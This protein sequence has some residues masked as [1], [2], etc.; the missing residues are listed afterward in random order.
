MSTFL[1]LTNDA[2]LEAGVDL[3]EL[4]SVNFASANS[5]MYARFKRWVRRAYKDIQIMRND[6]QYRVGTANVIVSPRIRVEQAAAATAPVADDT[7]SCDDTSAT[8]TALGAD[9]LSGTWAGGD[10]VAYLDFLDLDGEFKFN[11]L[12]SRVTPTADTGILRITGWGRYDLATEVSDLLEADTKSFFIQSTGG[13]TEQ[14]NTADMDIHPLIHVPWAQWLRTYEGAYGGRGTPRFITTTPE[15]HYDL[16]PR[17]DEQYVLNFSYTKDVEDLTNYDDSP[18]ALPAIYHDA[19]MWKA[20]MYYA[21]F[22]KKPSKYVEAENHWRKYQI[23]LE[24][25]QM[26]EVTFGQCAYDHVG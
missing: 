19:I 5:R 9:L 3:N 11:E 22:D 8:F 20:V 18:T 23:M 2:M 4:T 17:P 1:D 10:A 16:Y 25:N 15:G 21:A 7:F 14:D 12:V 6:Q 13:S 26:P 24:S